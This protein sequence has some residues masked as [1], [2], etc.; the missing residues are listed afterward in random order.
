MLS[1]YLILPAALPLQFTQPLTEMSTR[2]M[3][4]KVFLG[5]R[6]WLVGEDNNLT[7]ICQQNIQII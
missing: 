4:K 7:A 6:A 1:I 2:K 3:N 5:S